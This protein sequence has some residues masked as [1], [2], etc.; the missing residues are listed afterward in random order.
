[1]RTLS[2]LRTI[3]VA[4]WASS[5]PWTQTGLGALALLA[6]AVVPARS[7]ASP[8]YVV[9]MTDGVTSVTTS[10]S[11]VSSSVDAMS[12]SRLISLFQPRN[13]AFNPDQSPLTV[14]I[15]A[16]GIGI[17]VTAD[18]GSPA[19]TM[20]IPSLKLTQTFQG[21]TRDES[22]N[23]I[24]EWFKR[25]NLLSE[26]ARL[27]AKL[28]PVDPL[29]GNPNSAQA[30]TVS[31]A[32]DRGFSRLASQGDA[33]SGGA[34]ASPVRNSNSVSA[35]V[36]YRMGFGQHGSG[37]YTLPL[38][39]SWR[40][41]DD[42]RHQISFDVPLTYQSVEGGHVFALGLG[43]GYS[44]PITDHWVLTAGVDY[45]LAASG[46][47]GANGH[48]LTG[49]LTSLLTLPVARGFLVHVGNMVGYSRT[50]PMWSRD[51]AV[52]PMIKEVIL[53]N[54]V[55]LYF[56]TSR[57]MRSSGIELFATDTRFLGTTLYD[58]GFIEVGASFG[59]SRVTLEGGKRYDNVLRI[60]VSGII[61]RGNNG[62]TL[63][64]GYM[65]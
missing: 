37:S 36:R 63:N 30:R 42:A 31:T 52:D 64:T 19:L 59:I 29:A 49:T 45:G 4:L 12:R 15:Q 3:T 34:D 9:D 23:A 8:L 28:S 58:S 41:N 13:P 61:A 51:Y 7:F 25:S 60:G 33:P 18:D 11:A 27:S 55:M 10:Y 53:R 35:G 43:S 54:G 20:T 17:H 39:Y 46:D 38:G 56:S 24:I 32:F 5:R 62:L 47:L 65:F 21:R 40:F 22:V 26:F 1:M 6:V 50:L 14:D 57:L 2:R 44:H 48:V 16:R